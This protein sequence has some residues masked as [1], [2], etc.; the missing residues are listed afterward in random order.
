MA[1]L[2]SRV[3]RLFQ[4]VG[5]TLAAQATRGYAD[6]AAPVGMSFTFGSPGAAFYNAATNVRQVDVPTFSGDIGILPSHVPTL[7]V[8]KPGRLSVYEDEGNVNHFVVS[9]G[10]VTVNEDSSVQILAEEACRLEDIDPALARSG[11]EKAQQQLSAA[12][13]DAERTEAQVA[14]EFHEQVVKA[15]E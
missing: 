1:S 7:A 12:S 4:A 5:R 10:S 2:V 3:P 13:T 15:I 6:A 14:I 9:S 11:L 8:L